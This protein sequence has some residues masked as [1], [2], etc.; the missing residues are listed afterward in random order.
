MFILSCA[1]VMRVKKLQHCGEELKNLFR[2]II[3]N[4]SSLL[5]NIDHVDSKMYISW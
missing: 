1:E 5:Q 4:R 3:T 2:T